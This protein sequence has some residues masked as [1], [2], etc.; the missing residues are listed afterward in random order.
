MT[1]ALILC[2][3]A[4]ASPVAARDNAKKENATAVAAIKARV[5]QLRATPR[6]RRC[7]GADA[8][9]CLASLSFAIPIGTEPVWLGGGLKLPGPVQRDIYGQP[10]SAITS[11]AVLF[12]AK[13]HGLFGPNVVNAELHLADGEHVDSL[14]FFLKSSPLL[15]QTAADWDATHVFEIATAVLG[16]ACIGSDRL[17]FYR[18][19]D[20]IQRQDSS[21]NVRSGVPYDRRVAS[22]TDGEMEICGVTM[23]TSSVSGAS[24]S[25]TYGGSSVEFRRR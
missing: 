13:D 4:L 18:Q 16:P 10:I 11:F 7:L 9:T 6:D 21:A 25:G 8:V 23:A 19:Y 5:E 17:A 15:A 20:R 1:K 14:E 12:S 2:A 3:L 22:V 24:R